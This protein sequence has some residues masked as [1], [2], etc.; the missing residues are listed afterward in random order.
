M[1]WDHSLNPVWV[2]NNHPHMQILE[3]SAE[4][5][6]LVLELGTSG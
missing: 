4:N 1:S 3:G 5:A 6:N 2:Q